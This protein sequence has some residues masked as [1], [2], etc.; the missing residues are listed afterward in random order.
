M[1]RKS[2]SVSDHRRVILVLILA[3]VSEGCLTAVGVLGLIG[4][5]AY[6]TKN[7]LSGFIIVGIIGLLLLTSCGVLIRRQRRQRVS[8]V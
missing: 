8:E 3:M 2:S 6:G 5:A 1:L 4:T 7:W